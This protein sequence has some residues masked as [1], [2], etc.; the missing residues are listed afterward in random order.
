MLSMK[1]KRHYK[2]MSIIMEG[3][4]NGLGYRHTKLSK[5]KISKSQMKKEFITNGLI[6][7]KTIIG[8]L[9]SDAFL[10]KLETEFQNSC[11][12]MSQSIKN[13]KMILFVEKYLKNLGFKTHH[14]TYTRKTG[15]S[16]IN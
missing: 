11:F 4:K 2:K 8:L 15:I 9:L 5:E 7:D 3:N 14:K 10:K 1:Q 13:R 12:M 6:K 16:S